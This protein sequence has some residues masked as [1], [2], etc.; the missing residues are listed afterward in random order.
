M[1]QTIYNVLP[2][3]YRM[4]KYH[5]SLSGLLGSELTRGGGV[6]VMVIKKT[7]PV[8]AALFT[9]S[10]QDRNLNSPEDIR[11]VFMSAT[12]ISKEEYDQKINNREGNEIVALQ[13]RLFKEYRVTGTPSVNVR[14]RIIL[15]I[16]HFMRPQQRRF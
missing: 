12:G 4:A 2:E 15:I 13:E 5:V 1:D 3:G 14:G 7:E 11:T 6:L 16:L 8:E 9:A 10:I